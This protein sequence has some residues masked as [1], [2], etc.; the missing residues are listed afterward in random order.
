MVYYILMVNHKLSVYFCNNFVRSV[1]LFWK[2]ILESLRYF[3]NLKNSD[4]L[5]LLFCKKVL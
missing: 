4:L 5:R 3:Y 2:E 1:G